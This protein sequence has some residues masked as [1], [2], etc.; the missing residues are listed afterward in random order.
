MAW[1]NTAPE[2]DE[3]EVAAPPKQGRPTKPAKP[4][5]PLTRREA[6]VKTGVQTFAMPPCQASYVLGH[7]F[8]IGPTLLDGSG[9]SPI[10]H[11]EIAHYQANTGVD[12]NAWEACTLRRLSQVYIAE[13]YK[14]KA[15]DY[16]APWQQA[17]YVT[18]V[19]QA[20]TQSVKN[21]MRALAAI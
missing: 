5:V 15:A 19:K 17:E 14:S 9:E 2:Q 4:A 12:L 3:P 13:S 7:L 11:A 10:T 6:L 16:P 20:K 1:L 18:P 21:A 8:D